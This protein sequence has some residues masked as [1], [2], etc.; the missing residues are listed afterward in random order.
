MSRGLMK[1][2]TYYPNIAKQSVATLSLFSAEPSLEPTLALLANIG[3]NG[4]R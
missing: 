2:R 4:R 1:M 3:L